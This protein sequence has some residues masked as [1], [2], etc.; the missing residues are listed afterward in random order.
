MDNPT[1]V[2]IASQLGWDVGPIVALATAACIGLY[3][4][5]FKLLMMLFGALE[6][7]ILTSKS[8]LVKFILLIP[9]LIVAI[10]AIILDFIHTIMFFW[11]GYQAAKGVRDWAHKGKKH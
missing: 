6:E 1:L 10:P 4:I 2:W 7:A 3:I 5:L 9:F 11:A 8:P